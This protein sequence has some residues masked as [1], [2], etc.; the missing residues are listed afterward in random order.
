MDHKLFATFSCLFASSIHEVTFIAGE[1]FKKEKNKDMKWISAFEHSLATRCL[2]VHLIQLHYSLLGIFRRRSMF[3]MPLTIWKFVLIQLS[4]N[5]YGTCSVTI[6]SY[7]PFLSI[8]RWR[9]LHFIQLLS[10]VKASWLLLSLCSQRSLW[11]T[12]CWSCRQR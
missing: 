5:I 9:K 12:S 11:I 10:S 4:L 8:N 1:A 3:K 2:V 7:E 6:C